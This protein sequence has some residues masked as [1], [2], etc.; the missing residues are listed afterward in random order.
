MTDEDEAYIQQATQEHLESLEKKRL[1]VKGEEL[2]DAEV[3]PTHGP[4]LTLPIVACPSNDQAGLLAITMLQQILDPAEW[5]LEVISPGLLTG[6]IVELVTATQPAI[7]CIAALPPDG[8]LHASRLCGMIRAK[9]PHTKI[10]VGRWGLTE[11]FDENRDQLKEAGADM[12]AITLVETQERLSDWR[13]NLLP[14]DTPAESK[15]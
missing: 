14:A 8:L 2:D 12:I 9:A 4:Q 5:N 13:P 11:D 1:R 7:F 3:N 10:I 6:E 15:S